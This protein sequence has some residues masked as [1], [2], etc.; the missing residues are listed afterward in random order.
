MS[1]SRAYHSILFIILLYP[2]HPA[3]C[4]GA[5][6][7]NEIEWTY[8]IKEAKAKAAREDKLI[9]VDLYADWCG[10]CK[11]M[12]KNTWAHPSVI[13]RS[14][15]YVFL[16]LDV[17]NDKDGIELMHRFVIEGLPT[18]LI[19]DSRGDE[20]ER[21]AGYLTAKE[22]LD[23]LQ[24]AI[25]NPSSL[26]NLRATERRNPKDINIRF[27]LATKLMISKDFA[28][29]EERFQSIAKQDPDNRFKT[30]DLALYYLALCQ[31]SRNAGSQSLAT[32]ERMRKEFP[33]SRV[34]P[35]A[36]LLS[37]E[38]LMKIGKPGDAKTLIEEFLKNYP[39]HPLTPR[40]VFLLNQPE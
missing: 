16:K 22:F 40:A 27:L 6:P 23:K 2:F 30:T 28:G 34:S 33:D 13:A 3:L 31:L 25:D 15:N 24:A 26:G 20:F 4:L 36:T 35:N 5:E 12:D 9:I 37:S 1:L 29:A 38:I 10:W 17:E 19:L 11:Q 8:S 39:G 18:I 7:S 21:L 32:I 14:R